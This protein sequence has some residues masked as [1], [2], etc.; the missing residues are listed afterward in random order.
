M[1]LDWIPGP[2]PR[3]GCEEEFLRLWRALKLDQPADRES[4]VARFGE[5]TIPA[6]ETL[7][8]PRVGFDSAADSWA[9]DAFSRR[10]DKSLTQDAFVAGLHGFYVLELVPRCD[11]LPRYTNGSPGGYVEAYSF[12]GQFLT[13]CTEII[14]PELLAQAYHSKLPED[15]KRYA[16]SL[17]D[18][19]LNGAAVVAGCSRFHAAV[20]PIVF[21]PEVVPHRDTWNSDPAPPTGAKQRRDRGRTRRPRPRRARRPPPPPRGT[22][23]RRPSRSHRPSSSEPRMR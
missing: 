5:I 21:L 2:K 6:F 4:K 16:T 17:L 13:D 8:A 9:H 15:T 10:S 7:K 11:G 3:P 14:G 12:R 23:A 18:H 20:A 19:A 1:G 22:S